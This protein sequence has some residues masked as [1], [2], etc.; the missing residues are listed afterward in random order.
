VVF[1]LDDILVHIKFQI[2]TPYLFSLSVFYL[3]LL[4]LFSFYEI[5]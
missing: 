5:K 1:D 4:L 2:L 3:F